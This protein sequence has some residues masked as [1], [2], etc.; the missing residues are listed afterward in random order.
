MCPFR[1]D[2]ETHKPT[3]ISF[4]QSPLMRK[5]SSQTRKVCHSRMLLFLDFPRDDEV[6]VPSGIQKLYLDKN[7]PG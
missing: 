6:L 2:F 1:F 3:L 5:G 7:I 4:G